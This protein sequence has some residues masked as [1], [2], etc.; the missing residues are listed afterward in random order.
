MAKIQRQ[1][2]KTDTEIVAAGGSIANL[3]GDDQMYVSA[4][5]INKT[6]K[7]AI[8]DGDIAGGSSSL[9]TVAQVT[10][11][12]LASTFLTG[13]NAT[14]LGGGVLAGT[15]VRSTSAPLNGDSDYVYT[16]AAGSLNDYVFTKALAVSE[17]FRGKQVVVKFAYKYNGNDNELQ[18]Y[19]RDV[20]NS[21]FLGTDLFI[22][23][24]STTVS[25]YKATVSVPQTCT[26]L[27]VGFQVKVLNSGKILE[28]DD[29]DLELVKDVE[30][31]SPVLVQEVDSFIRLRGTNGYG[32]TATRIPRLLT[33]ETSRGSDVTYADSAINGSS[34]TIN[35]AGVYEINF[36]ADS[37]SACQFGLSVNS[38]QLTT[39]VNAINGI[40]AL[41]YD[42]GGAGD[43]GHVS[44]SGYFNAGDVIRPHTNGAAI[45]YIYN[46]SIAK[47]G[48]LRIVNASTNN[49]IE[50]SSSELRMEG[51]STRGATATAIARFDSTALLRG[52][53]FLVESDATLGTRITILKKGKLGISANLVLTTLN[54]SVAI[55][56]NQANLTAFPSVASEN[57]ASMTATTATSRVTASYYGAV[58]VG[59]VFRVATSGAITADAGNNLNLSFQEQDVQVSVS[60]VLPQFSESDSSVRLSGAN[61]YGSTNTTTR[62]F[63]NVLQNLG[64]AIQY[65]D[66][67]TL[68]GRFVIQE[69][70][71][72]NISYTES[73]TANTNDM[74]VA[75]VLNGTNI[76]FD[77]QVYNTAS[78]ATKNANASWSGYLTQG[79]LIQAQVET[80]A[81]NNGNICLFTMSKVGKPN[82]TGV[83]VTPFANVNTTLRENVRVT[84]FSNIS[85]QRV[86]FASTANNEASQLL[87]YDTASGFSRI[88]A[89]QRCKVNVAANTG[90]GGGTFASI[91]HRNSVGTVLSNAFQSNAAEKSMSYTATLEAGDDIIVVANAALENNATNTFLSVTAEA[92]SLAIASETDQFSTDTNVLSYAG[93][94]LYTLSTLANAPIGT[95]IT[96][97]YAANGNVA[98]QTTT[99]PTQTTSDMNAN[100]IR[101]YPRAFNVAST[102][103]QPTK[104]AIQIGKGLK[105]VSLRG[106][107]AT[108][109]SLSLTLDDVVVSNTTERGLA[110]SYNDRTGILI[111]DAGLGQNS[112]NTV[113][114]FLDTETPA[115]TTTCYIVVNAAKTPDI[116]VVGKSNLNRSVT[117]FLPSNLVVSTTNIASLAFSN[118][119]VGKKYRVFI[120]PFSVT[121]AAGISSDFTA[122][123]NGNTVARSVQTITSSIASIKLE[124]SGDFVATATTLTCNWAVSGSG[125]T[126]FGNGTT[127]QT[128]VTL[129]E[130]NNEIDGDF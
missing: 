12:D 100:G 79:D 42:N 53:A 18:A 2:I 104:V 63:S 52:D 90:N 3:P 76:S 14:P 34:F 118:L 47:Q 123:H 78:T 6:L 10:G 5:G 8:I 41:A 56:K 57:L 30:L 114:D 117:K 4:N 19:I 1:G 49:K 25:I 99:A 11:K 106:F 85:S 124:A 107:G 51:C 89:V 48:K 83:D 120:R 87:R 115:T 23:A 65:E 122:I 81:N 55:T 95:F 61:G 105:G 38:T 33:L 101:L 32:S 39:N 16:Q 130:L 15:F 13:N 21:A 26:Q 44:Y 112:A 126:L 37:G 94:A 113:R 129:V 108:G 68:G 40:T 54:T 109:K 116:S 36:S 67:A 86:L 93:S 50:I 71:I 59:D 20:T 84:G 96:W 27:R 7:Q 58:S 128:S 24:S 70:G 72:Y 127:T 31:S 29:F 46:F 77:S 125:G 82:V 102:A 69:S 88:I 111:I 28:I 62:R 121:N 45:S 66:S 98:T 73:S 103:A 110:H 91:Q 43:G 97:T 80:A 92:D 75:I 17:K 35:T 9:D 22:P 119:I 74:A 60:N 64:T